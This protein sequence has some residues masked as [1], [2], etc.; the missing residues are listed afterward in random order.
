MTLNFHFVQINYIEYR[1]RLNLPARSKIN[2]NVTKYSRMEQIK[3]KPQ[4]TISL[5]IF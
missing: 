4:K 1:Q 2:I 3:F 5:Q